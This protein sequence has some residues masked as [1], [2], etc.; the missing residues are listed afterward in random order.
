MTPIRLL[1]VITSPTRGGIEEVV[2][3]LLRRL[4]PAE[5]RLALAAP[6]PP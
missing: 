1:F 3:A 6:A 5:F 4:D 2:L